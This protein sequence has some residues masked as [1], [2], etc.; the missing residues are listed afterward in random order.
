MSNTP[1][2]SPPPVLVT[3]GRIATGDRRRPWAEAVLVVGGV[4]GFVGSAAEGRKRAR[5]ARVV[6]VGRAELTLA[7]AVARALSLDG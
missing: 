1:T 7:D 5:D 6:D 4:V 3:N 2:Q